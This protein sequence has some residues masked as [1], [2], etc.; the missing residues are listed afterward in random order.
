[1]I[2]YEIFDNKNIK[3]AQWI[4]K[5]ISNRVPFIGI[6][7]AQQK[8]KYDKLKLIKFYKNKLFCHR[9]FRDIKVWILIKI[10]IP[11]NCLVLD[12]LLKINQE[13]FL[14]DWTYKYVCLFN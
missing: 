1:M 7:L 10:I 12:E 5:L 9:L 3:P 4:G 11:V 14:W 13:I 6:L 2:L 8:M